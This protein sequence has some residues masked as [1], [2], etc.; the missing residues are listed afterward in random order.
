MLKR[1]KEFYNYSRQQIFDDKSRFYL[2]CSERLNIC[3][4]FNW[5]LSKKFGFILILFLFSN[6]DFPATLFSVSELLLGKIDIFL[7]ISA[8]LFFKC[9]KTARS[10]MGFHYK[11]KGKT[12]LWK[13]PKQHQR[14]GYEHFAHWKHYEELIAVFQNV[15]V[16]NQNSPGSAN[17]SRSRLV[18]SRV[19]DDTSYWWAPH[20]ILHLPTGEVRFF[21]KKTRAILTGVVDRKHCI[22]FSI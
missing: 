21:W 3:C 12:L 11:K 7:C 13:P 2:L 18:C 14:A 22:I 17:V 15:L 8:V 19:N 5:T 4:R 6:F 1:R 10:H 20:V 9:A 16:N